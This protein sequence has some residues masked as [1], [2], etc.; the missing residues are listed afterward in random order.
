MACT[1]RWISND[2]VP[3]SV[4]DSTATCSPFAVEVLKLLDDGK[5]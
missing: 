2:G 5:K 4:K 1:R 3:I